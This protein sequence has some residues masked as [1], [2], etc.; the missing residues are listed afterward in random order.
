MFKLT[1]SFEN[2]VSLTAFVNKMGDQV[3]NGTISH[4]QP[5]VA[6]KAAPK[7]GSKAAKAAKAA[8]V[9]EPEVDLMAMPSKT[10]APSTPFPSN[11]PTDF[12]PGINTESAPVASQPLAQPVGTTAQPLPSAPTM[13]M[14]QAPVAAPVVEQVS[15]ERQKWN[16]ACIQLVNH[17]Q[18][19]GAAK[20]LT[21]VQLGQVL[22]QS[23]TEAGCP[24]GS[25][26]SKITDAQIQAF[27]PV[28]YKNVEA[29]IK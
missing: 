4:D 17:L 19:Q 2:L 5:I 18:T 3:T 16:D 12:A 28:L 29:I 26:I 9:G 13:A 27:Y 6:E 20:G 15:P 22:S 25:R 7:R 11:A 24:V 21:E 1:V 14:P 10:Q 23:F 8:K